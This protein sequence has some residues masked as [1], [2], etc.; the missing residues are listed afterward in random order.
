MSTILL[1][2]FYWSDIDV[3]NDNQLDELCTFLSDHYVEDNTGTLR[4]HYSKNTLLWMLKQTNYKWCVGV[5]YKNKL[6]GFISAIPLRTNYGMTAFVNFLCVHKNVRTKR[7]ASVLIKEITHR[8]HTQNI[9]M[10]IYTGT[11]L[12]GEIALTTYW[13]RYLN[14]KK[15]LQHHMIHLPNH[16]TLSRMVKLYD[17][18]NTRINARKF[19]PYDVP[20]ICILLNDYLEKN[21]ALYCI[22][23]EENILHWFSSPNNTFVIEENNHIVAFSPII[24]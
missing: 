14:P 4:F 3:N 17:I 23:N 22:W 5:R 6:C 1:D 24:V 21:T 12:K 15:L 9:T 11:K 16:M 8:I 18:K 10:A 13:Q 20:Q 7:L 2:N 19:M